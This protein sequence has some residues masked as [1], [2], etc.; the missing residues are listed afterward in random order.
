MNLI[1]T[2]VSPPKEGHLELGAY[3][4]IRGQGEGLEELPAQ[5]FR[6][7]TLDRN[8]ASGTRVLTGTLWWAVNINGQAHMGMQPG[9]SIAL[10]H[11]SIGAGGSNLSS[12]HDFHF[13]RVPEH[14]VRKA[15]MALL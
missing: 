1:T 11:V 5:V 12:K 14:I 3:Y 8:F 7:E 10:H 6:L 9:H 4:L 15:L 2:R 13:E